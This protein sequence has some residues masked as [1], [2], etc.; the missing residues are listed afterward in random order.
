MFRFSEEARHFL[1]STVSRVDFGPTQDTKKGLLVALPLGAHHPRNH[2]QVKPKTK[3]SCIST[4]SY[5]FKDRGIFQYRT[6]MI[7]FGRYK[8]GWHD[9]ELHNSY[10]KSDVRM[11]TSRKMRWIGHVARM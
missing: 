4:I 7:I 11:I 9:M 10:S 1:L 5:V 2:L 3:W 6:Q 8:G